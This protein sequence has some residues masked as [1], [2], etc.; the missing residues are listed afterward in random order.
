MTIDEHRLTHHVARRGESR[1]PVFIT[2]HRHRIG[3]LRGVILRSQQAAKGWLEAEQLKVIP[4][5]DLGVLVL[6]LVMPRKTYAGFFG[7]QHARKNLILVAQV[8]VHGIRKVIVLIS[9]KAT[10][11]TREAAGPYEANQ[12]PGPLD[13]QH[14]QQHLVKEREDSRIGAQP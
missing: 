9:A 4:C 12:F 2:E 6:G 5:D 8:F 3:I 7:C 11:R 10:G 13:R 14:T 1:F